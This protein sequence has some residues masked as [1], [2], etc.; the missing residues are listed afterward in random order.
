MS[1]DRIEIALPEITPAQIRLVRLLVIV[2]AILAMAGTTAFTVEPEEE[3]VVL[4][5]GRYNRTVPP[6]LHF[7]LPLIIETVRK[8]P[9]QR[10]LKEEFGFRTKN[11]ATRTEYADTNL[12]GE[13]LMLTGD[14]NVAV[15]E[16]IAQYRVKDPYKYLFK[17]RNVRSTFRDM[18]EAVMRQIIG[19]RSVSEVL[20]IG[21]QEIESEAERLLQDMCDEY[22]TGIQVEQ[23]VL[24]NV[25]P[26][27]EVKP[28]F[29]EV[30]QAQQ[31]RE[32]QINDA[33]TAFNKVIPAARG[34]AEETVARAGGY[35]IERT[36]RAQGEAERFTALR[37][38]YEKAPKVT[39]QRLYLETMS[40]VIPRAKSKVVLSEGGNGVLPL[41][42]LEG[43]AK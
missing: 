3:G 1:D 9:T 24:Q 19:D 4:R 13:K 33:K 7:K 26:P 41:L 25:N 35:A 14:L 37:L 38:A 17:V 20:T 36:N 18:N 10:Q 5:L 16:W 30:N 39:R 34:Q 23:V 31:E 6:G 12:S 22:D 29:D 28:S 21:R 15:V 32:R 8:V 2:L 43:G 27:D 11:A 42:N 40:E